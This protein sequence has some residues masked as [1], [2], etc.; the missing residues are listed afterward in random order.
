MQRFFHHGPLLRPSILALAALLLQGCSTYRPLDQG[1]HVPWAKARQ[2][3]SADSGRV[4]PAGASDASAISGRV[5][6]VERGDRLSALAREYG[7][8]VEAL[9]RGA[10]G[11]LSACV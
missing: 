11:A 10:L 3:A 8:S 1:S 2:I 7:V 6:R 9:V 4:V 5:H